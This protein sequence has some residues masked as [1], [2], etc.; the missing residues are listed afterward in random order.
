MFK[1]KQKASTGPS[2]GGRI[3]NRATAG[4]GRRSSCTTAT[5]EVG[6]VGNTKLIWTLRV[7]FS[8]ETNCERC[9][10]Q[11]GRVALTD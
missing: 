5:L 6:V 3:A 1:E 7:Y 2:S 9:F 10:L 8:F 4:R 11:A